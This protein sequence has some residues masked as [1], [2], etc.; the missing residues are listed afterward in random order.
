MKTQELV[1]LPPRI[2]GFRFLVAVS[3]YNSLVTD[4]LLSGALDTFHSFGDE[5]AQVSV[6][7]VPGALE[8]PFVASRAAASDAYDGILALGCVIRGET[9]HYEAVVDGVTQG[10][11]AVNAQ[12]TVP[13]V[14][15]IL[16]TDTLLQALD[17][18]GGKAGHKG[19]EGAT[20][21]HQMARLAGAIA[22]E[23]RGG[24]SS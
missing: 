12:G 20:T 15:G 18:V 19:V 7:R 10:L 17:R 6:V 9:G 11:T 8:L 21:L 2:G 5:V 22:P 24:R 23:S 14:F 4:R 16:T 13:V 3:Q 1:A